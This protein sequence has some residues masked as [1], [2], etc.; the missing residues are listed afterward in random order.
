MNRVFV[1]NEKA[2]APVGPFDRDMLNALVQSGA[3]RS[4][5][6]VAGD[7]EDSWT[8]AA[9]HP[10]T[11]DC[12]AFWSDRAG[13]TG[14]RGLLG[15]G[16]VERATRRHAAM[17]TIRESHDPDFDLDILELNT[18]SRRNLRDFALLT[19]GLNTLVFGGALALGLNPISVTFLLSLFVAGNISLS[20]I[21]GVVMR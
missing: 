15:S 19:L 2:S 10:L 21:F 7:G 3:V 16:L 14:R 18:G 17:M 20:W 6:L 11:A 4:T 5:T 9:E 12:G 13:G 1:W 8:V